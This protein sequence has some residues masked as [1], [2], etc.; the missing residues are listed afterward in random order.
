MLDP[1]R[2]TDPGKFRRKAG[3]LIAHYQAERLFYLGI[4]QTDAAVE[5]EGIAVIPGEPR[6]V[7]VKRLEGLYPD[8][9]EGS[10][11]CPYGLGIENIHGRKDYGQI[12]YVEADL[13]PND[14]AEVAG[15]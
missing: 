6:P 1:D 7:V 4:L 8:P 9:G 5:H 14:G 10:H 11:G 3:R 13:A 12:L 2:L 15:I